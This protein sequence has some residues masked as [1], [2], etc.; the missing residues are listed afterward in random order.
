MKEKSHRNNARK[1]FQ[2]LKSDSETCCNVLQ[3][4]K[5]CDRYYGNTNIPYDNLMLP[6]SI[7]H[8]NITN[9]IQNKSITVS[10]C[11]VIASSIAA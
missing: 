11:N 8:L 3:Y 9:N 6:S 5:K 2:N 10:Y 7:R 1:F 4:R